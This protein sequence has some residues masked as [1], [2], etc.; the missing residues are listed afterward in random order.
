MKERKFMDL[1]KELLIQPIIS[2]LTKSKPND[3]RSLLEH[4]QLIFNIKIFALFILFG[5]V[6]IP[7]LYQYSIWIRNISCSISILGFVYLVILYLIRH[8]IFDYVIDDE[9]IICITMPSF[10]H[11]M[12]CIF[13]SNSDYEL[14]SLFSSDINT[15]ISNL[16]NY[17][18]GKALLD[19]C[20]EN[21]V[22]VVY[23]LFFLCA[24]F[25]IAF[26]AFHTIFFIINFENACN[27]AYILIRNHK[28]LFLLSTC[29]YFAMSANLLTRT[30]IFIIDYFSETAY[31]H[32][33]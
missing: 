22:Y 4:N 29:A 21:Y 2:I 9:I 14:N 33:L 30:V 32:F 31:S 10:M 26:S 18:F 5:K 1:I 23:T 20:I 16:S 12:Y 8:K 7:P 24:I 25:F 6:I 28:Y 15:F 17:R 3:S 13:L 19:Y 11:L 27:S